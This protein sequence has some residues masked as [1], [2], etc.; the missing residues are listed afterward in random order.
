MGV[1]EQRYTATETVSSTIK[2]VAAEMAKLPPAAQRVQNQMRDINAKGDP[3]KELQ[4]QYERQLVT[5]EI[6]GKKDLAKTEELQQAKQK[7]LAQFEREREA[8][9]KKT[10]AAE[11]KAADVSAR[12][13]QQFVRSWREPLSAVMSMANGTASAFGGASSKVTGM[14]SGIVGSF[15]TGGVVG[16][17]LGAT[18]SAAALLSETFAKSGE[19]AQKAAEKAAEATAKVRKQQ[20]E[21]NAKLLEEIK[22]RWLKEQGIK[23]EDATLT[24]TRDEYERDLKAKEGELALARRELTRRQQAIGYY[25]EDRVAEQRKLVDATEYEVYRLR[26]LF[27]TATN[28]L[29]GDQTPAWAASWDRYTKALY[30]D[31]KKGTK[32]E[33]L[34]GDPALDRLL[35]EMPDQSE[36]GLKVS[37]EK[38]RKRE[39]AWE[40]GNEDAALADRKEKQAAMAFAK[41]LWP[42]H[43]RKQRAEELQRGFIEDQKKA[44]QEKEKAYRAIGEQMAAGIGAGMASFFKTKDPKDLF[45]ALIT[46]AV[47]IIG[48]AVGGPAGG[49]L[50]GFLGGMFRD[51]GSPGIPQ[52]RAGLAALPG[53]NFDARLAKFDHPIEYT[54][55]AP[56]VAAAGGLASVDHY[57]KLAR[58]GLPTGGGGSVVVHAN[59][60]ALDPLAVL[61]VIRE[62]LA[63]ALGRLFDDRQVGLLASSLSRATMT[64]RST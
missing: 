56:A 35:R 57:N 27:N 9:I 17:A 58:Q 19:A 1:Y 3:L 12:S 15:A 33:S 49:M 7:L 44:I 36:F 38:E 22:L 20:D 11:T 4:R 47:G 18:T 45:G 30:P 34:T 41:S 8:I 46:G 37:A 60:E 24:K 13:A 39:E 31:K 23:P 2:Q 10:S 25:G 51:G 28:K 5:L 14:V 40:F 32:R 53:V 26:G 54:L 55:S 50:S 43:Q 52:G 6:F 64:P 16:L 42:E 21:L 62:V 61:D 48:T 63:P 59:V 29:A